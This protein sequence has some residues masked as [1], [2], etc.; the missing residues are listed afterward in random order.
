MVRGLYLPVEGTPC[1]YE[2]DTR[3]RERRLAEDPGCVVEEGKLMQP[4]ISNHGNEQ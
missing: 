3:E 1:T 4:Q 2:V